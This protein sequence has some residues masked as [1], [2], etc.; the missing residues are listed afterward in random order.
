MMTMSF[1]YVADFGGEWQ[2]LGSRTVNMRADHDEIPVTAFK[3]AFTKLKFRVKGA[4][5]HVKNVRIV[6]G[7]GNDQ[8]FKI[9]R[10]FAPGTESRVLDLPGNKRVIKKIVMNYRSVQT[11]KGKAE[12]VVW[13]KH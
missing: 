7:N 4:P 2:R 10:K 6:F 9:D 3:G 11:P 5:I 8:N 1:T 13:G 12:V